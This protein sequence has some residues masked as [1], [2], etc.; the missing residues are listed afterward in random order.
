MEQK[1]SK[2]SRLKFLSYS[3]ITGFSLFIINKIPFVRNISSSQEN[4]ITIK[5]NPL[6]IPREK[7]G[8]KNV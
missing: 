1:K 3:L 8:V 4:K 2:I 5:F 6:S 7:S